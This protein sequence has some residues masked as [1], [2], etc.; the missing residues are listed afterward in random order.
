MAAPSNKKD[1][2][3]KELVSTSRQLPKEGE[4]YVVVD[5]SKGIFK[6]HPSFEKVTVLAMVKGEEGAR[7]MIRSQK[8]HIEE[9]HYHSVR[10][11]VVVLS[12]KYQVDHPQFKG[13]SAEI[14]TKGSYYCLPAKCHHRLECLEDGEMFVVIHGKPDYQPIKK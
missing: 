3:M 13:K 10:T 6:Q 7:F 5:S 1:E 2:G 4:D 11:E 14:L 8:G 12:G 9:D